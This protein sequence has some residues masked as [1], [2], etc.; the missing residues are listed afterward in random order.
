MR[1][2][3]TIKVYREKAECID[4]ILIWVYIII[5]DIKIRKVESG[6]LVR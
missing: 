6:D 1:M 4:V 3:T 5:I 2:I